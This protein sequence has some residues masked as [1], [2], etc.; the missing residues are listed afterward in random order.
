M[1]FSVWTAGGKLQRKA[2]EARVCGFVR[3][4]EVLKEGAPFLAYLRCNLREPDGGFN[5]LHLAEKRSD[6]V[7]RV[8]SPVL[9]EARGFRR[10]SP[11]GRIR[12][13]PPLI[14]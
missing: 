4:I 9:Q 8:M 5:C 11:I 7:E 12:Y 3:H 6:V 14:D 10:Y 1:A 2:R 13:L